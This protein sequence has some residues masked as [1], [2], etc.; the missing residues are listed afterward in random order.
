MDNQPFKDEIRFNRGYMPAIPPEQTDAIG[1]AVYSGQNTIFSPY[2]QPQSWP[3][4]SIVNQPATPL[5]QLVGTLLGGLTRGNIVLGPGNSYWFIGSGAMFVD[6]FSTPLGVASPL[7]QFAFH[8]QAYQAGLPSPS[9]PLLQIASDSAGNALA[10]LRRGNNSVVLTRRRSSTGAESAASQPS[11]VINFGNN[12]ARV[13]FP[14]ASTVAGQDQWGVYFTRNGF[15]G[16]GAH[17]LLRL[18]E[19]SEIA[20]VLGLCLGTAIGGGTAYTALSSLA[21]NGRISALS[22]APTG[23]TAPILRGSAVARSAGNETTLRLTKPQAAVDGDLLVAALAIE[24]VHNL[25]TGGSNRGSFAPTVTGAW[26]Q[27]GSVGNPNGETVELEQVSQTEFR[28]KLASSAIWNGPV[29]FS[30]AP[31]ALGATGLGVKWSAASSSVDEIGNAFTIEP[32]GIVAPAGWTLEHMVAAITDTKALAV[33]TRVS[34]AGD[35]A[36]ADFGVTVAARLFGV[37]S[38]YQDAAGVATTAT[39]TTTA[40]TTHTATFGA[41]TGATNLIVAHFT[42]AGDVTFTPQAPLA[43]AVNLAASARTLDFNFADDELLEVEAP[44]NVE[45]PPA[46]THC[47]ILGPVMV[48]GGA[49][50]GTALSPSVPNQFELYDLA[51][52]VFLNP[53]EPLVRVDARSHDGSLYLWT[54]NSLQTVVFTGE[55]DLPI[56]ARAVWPNTGI[57]NPSGATLTPLRAYAFSERGGPVRTTGSAQPDDDFARPVLSEMQNWR[58]EET[59]VGY[60]PRNLGM[61]VYANGRKLLVYFEG[62]GVWSTPLYLDDFYYAKREAANDGVMN[63]GSATLTNASKPWQV[64][65]VGKFV[66][67]NGAGAAGEP[68]NS[69][70]ETF[71]NP[72]EIQLRD[73]AQTT[74]AGAQVTWGADV[75][76]A[77]VLSAVTVDGR[78]YLAVG[79]ESFSQLYECNCGLGTAWSVRS[80]PRHGGAPGHQK[81]IKHVRTLA[82]FDSQVE[83]SWRRK[84]NL[85]ERLGKLVCTS[86]ATGGYAVADAFYVVTQQYGTTVFWESKLYAPLRK[87]RSWCWA[88]ATALYPYGSPS[89]LEQMNHTGAL[90]AWRVTD[91]GELQLFRLGILQ[92]FGGAV[93]EGDT[94]RIEL[95]ASG[96]WQATW[97]SPSG[98]TKESLLLDAQD[99]ELNEPLG[100]KATITDV[101]GVLDAGRAGRSDGHTGCVNLYTDYQDET[102]DRSFAY[103]PGGLRQYPWGPQLNLRCPMYQ[104]EACGVGAGQSP[105]LV[106]VDGTRRSDH[107]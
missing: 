66:T 104:V 79:D 51:N 70:I 76:T 31:T 84:T 48:V 105:A 93:E 46:G 6:D 71:I 19:E 32:L 49:L 92:M 30:T 27:A 69:L 2:G 5:L 83:L 12:V 24:N 15:G 39:N 60:D 88:K 97:L 34:V 52:T 29:V 63:G 28:W 91:A 3:G 9:A 26:T 16:D 18:V 68:L 81:T 8:G 100:I 96:Q 35:A 74:V 38:A 59:V 25:R 89:Q 55:A 103:A 64:E 53:V 82:N 65:D 47:F 67:V 62:Y 4:A 72:G 85:N 43:L 94:V 61:V 7:L 37:L 17:L 77:R 75:T 23:G 33:Y 106:R 87:E 58:A 90:I 98:D 56:L 14:A 10:G 101:G 42:G 40:T 57:A 20:P 1:D 41:A 45:S 78:L 36:F 54:R 13:T 95:L 21:T 80:V 102:P 50:D 107:V 73:A 22:L 86:G 11:N 99:G 44:R